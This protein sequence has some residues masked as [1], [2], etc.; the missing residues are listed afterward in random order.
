MLQAFSWSEY[1]L[2]VGILLIIYYGYVAF[3]YF[4]WEVLRLIGIQPVTD[5]AVSTA[6]LADYVNPSLTVEDNVEAVP[7]SPANS[8]QLFSDE[9]DAYLAEAPIDINKSELLFS[10]QII[11]SSYPAV[12]QASTQAEIAELILNRVNNKFP[13]LIL[14]TDIISLFG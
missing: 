4:K 14:P 12:K 9:L 7:P 10:L 1:L 6:N 3:R 13:N 5:A 11:V 8:I 2:F